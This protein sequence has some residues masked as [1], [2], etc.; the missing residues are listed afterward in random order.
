MKRTIVLVTLATAL[1]IAVAAPAGATHAE[2]PP[3]NEAAEP[4]TEDCRPGAD[5]HIV[6]PWTMMTQAEYEAMLLED[7]GLSAGD[8]LPESLV[9]PGGDDGLI[10]TWGELA[11]KAATATWE[12]CDH[13]D[14]GLAC[15]MKQTAPTGAVGWTTTAYNILDNHPFPS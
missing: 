8:A 11:H 15:V 13:N 2:P 3:Y 7:S 10:D 5:N 12:F 4:N 6:G 14:D 1:L 9:H